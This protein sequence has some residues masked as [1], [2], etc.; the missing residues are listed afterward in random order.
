MQKEESLSAFVDGYNIDSGFIDTLCSSSELKQKWTN[1]H[2]IRSVMRGDALIL[3]ADFSA[4]MELL[5]ENEEIDSSFTATNNIVETG[6][7]K[8]TLL[9]LKRWSTPLM[10]AGIA[11]SVCLIAVF[12]INS[13][14]T[15]DDLAATQ[16]VL[17][18]QPFTESIKPVSYNASEKESESSKQSN[19]LSNADSSNT[20]TNEEKVKNPISS[21][22]LSDIQK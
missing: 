22:E 4:K 12:S 21:K 18:T 14:N 19:R 16:P 11:A 15:S 17:Q 6:K 9:K 13:M 20:L 1:Y 3:G 10:Q 5:L 8:G 7:A 2:A